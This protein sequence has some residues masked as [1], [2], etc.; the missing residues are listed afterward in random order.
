MLSIHD[1]VVDI[2]VKVAVTYLEMQIFIDGLIFHK[3]QTVVNIKTLFSAQNKRI[4]DELL[5]GNCCGEVIV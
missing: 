3:V 2:V 1:P 5:K 4:F